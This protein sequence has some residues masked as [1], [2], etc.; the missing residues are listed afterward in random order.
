MPNDVFV[1]IT[2]GVVPEASGPSSLG[3]MILPRGNIVIL[4]LRLSLSL[5]KC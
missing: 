5:L 3:V 2:F 4:F 1:I